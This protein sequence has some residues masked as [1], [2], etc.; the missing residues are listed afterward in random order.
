M[1]NTASDDWADRVAEDEAGTAADEVRAPHL[2]AVPTPLRPPAS[3]SAVAAEAERS[4]EPGFVRAVVIGASIGFLIV[5]ALAAAA[6]ALLTPYGGPAALAVGA[7]VGA[8]GGVGFGGM[9]AA[10][11]RA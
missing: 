6:I 7:F 11:V 1:T 5:A 8:F 9:V 10:S 2:T 3:G 4:F